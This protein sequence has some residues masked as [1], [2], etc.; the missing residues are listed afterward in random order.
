[1]YYNIYIYSHHISPRNTS[2]TCL[3]RSCQT[4][5]A[6]VEAPAVEAKSG[7]ETKIQQT[8]ANETK[9]ETEDANVERSTFFMCI[10]LSHK[11]GHRAHS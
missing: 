2:S 7:G 5:G 11:C 8:E 4:E 9:D 10:F 6:D 3:T 1:M